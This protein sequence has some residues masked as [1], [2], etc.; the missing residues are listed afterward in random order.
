MGRQRFIHP[1]ACGL[2]LTL[3]NSCGTLNPFE[4]SDVDSLEGAIIADVEDGEIFAE[5]SVLTHVLLKTNLS[6][7]KK[8][9]LKW[10]HRGDTLE[11]TATQGVDQE[12]ATTSI[13]SNTT[14]YSLNLTLPQ[15]GTWT[16]IATLYD[17]SAVISQSSESVLDIEVTNQSLSLELTVSEDDVSATIAVGSTFEVSSVS[18]TD[19]ETGTALDAD[20]IITF[21]S[22]VDL[23]SVTSNT[24]DTICDGSI[25]VSN[26]NFSTCVQM[27]TAP[28]T[29]DNLSFTVTPINEFD[30]AESYLIK[31]TTDVLNTGGSAM[32]SEYETSTGFTTETNAKLR[33]ITNA[34]LNAENGQSY[35]ANLVSEN[36]TEVGLTW[37]VT[38]GALPGGLS[39]DGR[40]GTLSWSSFSITGNVDLSNSPDLTEISGVVAS[41]NNPGAFWVMDDSGGGSDFYAI[42][43][44]GNILQEYLVGASNHDWEDILIGPGPDENTEY[45]YIGDF[46]D[47]SSNRTNYKLVRIEE[48]TLPNAPSGSAITL[49]YDSFYF[50]YPDGSHNC[51]TMLI[52]W[53]T[54]I[55]YLVQKTSGTVNVYKFPSTMDNSW[56]SGNPVTLTQI[57]S[58]GVPNITYTAGD[59]SRDNQRIILRGYFQIYEFARPEGG[60]FEDIFLEAPSS[61]STSGVNIPQYEAIAYSSDGTSLF[62]ITEQSSASTVPISQSTASISSESTTI[63]GIP[64]ETGAFQMTFKVTD[65]AGNTDTKILELSVE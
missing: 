48:P 31:V 4:S 45:L 2:I 47:N 17:Q 38:S 20:V 65:S 54:E 56:T 8:S 44:A 50:E 59:S 12:S 25:Q 49:S 13:I 1:L 22:E 15:L 46:G 18:P 60:S 26:D 58:S 30:S 6:T 11:V 41:K 39:L 53:D 19:G 35:V 3:F 61:Y 9:A 23:T 36:S 33:I 24:D 43:Q 55:I 28:T 32:V 42:D 7:A 57:T 27:I 5:P 52:D 10:A 29:S 21:S 40:Q 62:T 16:F 14:E 63:S 51:E 64:T 34:L 37:E